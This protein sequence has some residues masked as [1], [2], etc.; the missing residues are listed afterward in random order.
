MAR[1]SDLIGW[2]HV[3]ACCITAIRGS[4]ASTDWSRSP[5]GLRNYR[6]KPALSLQ[7]SGLRGPGIVIVSNPTSTDSLT[8]CIPAK[9]TQNMSTTEQTYIMIK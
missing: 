4:I 1:T 2:E 9:H 3:D 8:I 7:I 5:G 6:G